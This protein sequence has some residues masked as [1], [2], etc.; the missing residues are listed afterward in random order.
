MR[1]V[2]LSL[3]QAR[4]QQCGL[5]MYD[6]VRAHPDHPSAPSALALLEGYRNRGMTRRLLALKPPETSARPSSA[7]LV[8][9]RRRLI[10][11]IRWRSHEGRRSQ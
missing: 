7:K 4:E 6:L 1:G 11:L 2:N 9:A 10:R 3:G 5:H 8:A